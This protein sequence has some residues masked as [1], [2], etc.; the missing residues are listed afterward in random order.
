MSVLCIRTYIYMAVNWNGTVA[1]SYY[2]ALT[3]FLFA[4]LLVCS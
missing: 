1:V 4:C 2:N 3:N